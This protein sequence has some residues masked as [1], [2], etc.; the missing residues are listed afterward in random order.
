MS[1]S[2]SGRL[3]E[4]QKQTQ[5]NESI[6]HEKA[7]SLDKKVG[8]VSQM[9]PER[10]KICF[11]RLTFRFRP[12]L[13]KDEVNRVLSSIDPSLGQTLFV[14]NSSIWPDG[15][16]IEVK[17]D[18]GCWRVVLVSE[19]KQQGKDMENIRNGVLVGKNKDRDL[20]PAGNAIERA[21]K[22]ISEFANFMIGEKHFPYVLFLEGSNF[23]TQNIV[24]TRPDGTTVTLNYTDGKINRLDRLTASN[25]GLPI[26]T[27]LCQNRFATVNNMLL[28]LQAVSIYTKG[29]GSQWSEDEMAEIMLGIA[30][31]S[32]KVLA[33]DLFGQLTEAK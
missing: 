4:Q 20:M 29:D 13:P 2:Q 33:S 22:N 11:P 18:N 21:Y 6:F 28:M 24:V 23:L 32:L 12:D 26:N 9:M 15:G 3:S 25:F 31:T 30:K 14:P 27:N 16:I 19:A 1:V 7:R 8:K 17:D 10:L 5:A